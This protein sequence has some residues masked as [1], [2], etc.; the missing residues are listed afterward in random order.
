MARD[1]VLISENGETFL[2]LMRKLREKENE[3]P[4]RYFILNP[5]IGPEPITG[6]SRMKSGTATKL[7]LDM[8][9]VKSMRPDCDLTEMLQIY[10]LLLEKV[11]YSEQTKKELGS[12]VDLAAK[13]LKSAVSIN[14]LCDSKRLGFL[15]CVDASECVP[16][17]GARPEH[18]K[19]FVS[20]LEVREDWAGFFRECH[21]VSAANLV[22]SLKNGLESSPDCLFI[23]VDNDQDFVDDQVS[24]NSQFFFFFMKCSKKNPDK[25]SQQ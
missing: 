23:M 17:Y 14:Y 16:T 9:L 21:S 24:Q 11:V 4:H 5:L 3:T 25:F 19:G 20:E 1:T 15:C 22:E 10:E 2:H 13:S 12:V 8:V 18:I 6:S 7:I